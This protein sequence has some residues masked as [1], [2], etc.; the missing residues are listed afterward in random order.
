[1][2]PKYPQ[3]GPSTQTLPNKDTKVGISAL[4]GEFGIP[5]PFVDIITD[6][7]ENK[8][9]PAKVL[10]SNAFK[11]AMGEGGSS[12][13]KFRDMDPYNPGQKLKEGWGK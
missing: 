9:L 11:I 2:N 7:T 8:K 5:H 3:D 12:G 6:W 13:G 4:P 1:M 10:K